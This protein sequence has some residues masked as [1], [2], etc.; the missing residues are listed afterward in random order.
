MMS[1]SG[2]KDLEELTADNLKLFVRDLT[3]ADGA[4]VDVDDTTSPSPNEKLMRTHS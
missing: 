1:K 3:L 4:E 2:P